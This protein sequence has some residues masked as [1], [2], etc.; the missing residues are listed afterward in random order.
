MKNK[1]IALLLLF[2]ITSYSQNYNLDPNFGNS[3]MVISNFL[4][5]DNDYYEYQTYDFEILSDDSIIL[6]A[7]SNDTTYLVKLSTNGDLDTSFGT[8][9]YLDLGL[10]VNTYLNYI[11]KTTDNK[12]L[13]TGE[14][15]TYPNRV[16]YKEK[17]LEDGSLDTSFANNGIFTSPIAG[18]PTL[19]ENNDLFTFE[20]E[21]N[22]AINYLKITKYN[23]Y[24]N[25]LDTSFGT[26]GITLT[27]IADFENHIQKKIFLD[28]NLYVFTYAYE[29][30]QYNYYV[31]SYTLDG[32]L[33][34][35]FGNDGVVNYYTSSD[36]KGVISKIKNDGK[37][38]F[39]ISNDTYCY[40]KQYT[41]NGILDNTF[42][43][44]G[45]ATNS[46]DYSGGMFGFGITDI[47]VKTDGSF[48]VSS[49][50][51]GEESSELR[52]NKFEENGSVDTD[53]Q[54]N[55]PNNYQ[56]LEEK[57]LIDEKIIILGETFWYNFNTK[58][59]L[60][61]YTLDNLAVNDIENTFHIYPNPVKN[62]LIITHNFTENPEYK[63]YDLLGKKVQF[64]KLTTQNIEVSTLNKGI[65]FIQIKNKTYKFIKN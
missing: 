26:N 45:I 47:L 29:N 55:F 15:G 5:Y 60:E 44:N 27:N 64:G 49:Y 42:G 23:D 10:N 53:F 12:I 24:G 38:L 32:D 14:Y 50:I 19:L 31:I 59:V 52:L 22:N 56:A 41:T 51:S 48:I 43:N 33:N 62:S 35:N 58:P 65:Y 8:N 36:Y 39:A 13:L 7:S 16:L 25:T 4:N 21:E 37:L 30:N 3:G 6:L 57:I 28:N 46:I 61:R 2:Y 40:F 17:R 34:T 18:N 54:F 63:I 9:G 11:D 1:L 20:N